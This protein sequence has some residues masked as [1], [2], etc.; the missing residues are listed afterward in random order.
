G[1][2]VRYQTWAGPGPEMPLSMSSYSKWQSMPE[3][4]G[5]YFGAKFGQRL[6]IWVRDIW[7]N[8]DATPF[9]ASV[10][11]DLLRWKKGSHHH[12]RSIEY[13]GD[14]ESLRL[15]GMTAEDR[16]VNDQGIS[17]ETVRTFFANRYAQ[18]LGLGPD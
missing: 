16:L 8:L 1:R 9:P 17:R 10:R 5:F 3:T 12:D 6:G 11:A 15:D 4:Y 7:N 18:A 14:K 2:S 13:V